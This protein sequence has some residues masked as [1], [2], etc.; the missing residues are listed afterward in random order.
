M[1]ARFYQAQSKYL[2]CL[3]Q[4]RKPE[5]GQLIVL[6]RYFGCL[7]DILHDVNSFQK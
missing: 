6:I 5:R 4:L 2:F 1:E 7:L 3:E